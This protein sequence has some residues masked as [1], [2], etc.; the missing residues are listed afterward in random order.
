MPVYEYRCPDCA[1]VF[2]KLVSFSQSS[3][4]NCP[5]CGVQASKLVST[6]AAIG[7]AGGSSAEAG[8]QVGM[9]A[10]GGGCGGSCC[11]G[12]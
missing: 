3:A 8:A 1:D 6:F 10:G 9:P 12:S 4:V 2:E 11:G 5:T 7:V